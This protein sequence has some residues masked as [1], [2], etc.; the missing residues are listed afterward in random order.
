MGISLFL[1]YACQAAPAELHSIAVRTETVTPSAVSDQPTATT[2]VE[3]LQQH[4]NESGTLASYSLESELLNDTLAFTVYLPPCYDPQTAEPYPVI[5]LLHGQQQDG[6]FWQDLGIQTAADELILGNNRP[7]FLIIMPVEEYYF[8][9][10][11]NNRYPDAILTE[12]LPWVEQNLPVCSARDCR[13]I[14]GVSRGAAWA[15]RLAFANPDIFSAL[16]AHSLSLFNGDLEVLPEWIEAIPAEQL[17]RIYAD[18]GNTDPAVKDA[19]AFEEALNALGVEHEWHLNGGRHNEDYW[20][21]QIP[22]YL[23]WYT[24]LWTK[25]IN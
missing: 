19:Y 5:Y 16:G 3:I 20:K 14:G 15:V 23:D 7:P 2:A 10:P 4:C 13:A 18:V 22:A 9:S 17:P 21:N 1:L 6:P 12:L 11:E 25:E 8:R 24:R